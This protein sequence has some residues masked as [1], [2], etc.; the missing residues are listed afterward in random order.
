M[1]AKFSELA[2]IDLKHIAD[3]LIDNAS[4]SVALSV[5]DSIERTIEETLLDHP[6]IGMSVSFSGKEMRYFP[7]KKYDAY[8]I[9]YTV[10]DDHIFIVRILHDK[11]DIVSIF[12][13]SAD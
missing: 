10:E 2:I 3:Y 8:N 1:F 7:A 11:Q 13:E 9:F 12:E 5:T 4:I 6:K